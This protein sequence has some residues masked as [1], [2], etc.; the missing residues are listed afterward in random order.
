MV[1]AEAWVNPGDVVVVPAHMAQQVTDAAKTRKNPKGNKRAQFAVGV[2]DL[3]L[4]KL[5][6]KLAEVGLR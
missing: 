6:G 3:S 1:C 5:R 4:N 2:P